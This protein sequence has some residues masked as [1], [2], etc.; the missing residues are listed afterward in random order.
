MTQ[1]VELQG[2]ARRRGFSLVELLVVIGI[3][4]MLI[5]LLL[6]AVQAAREAARRSECANNLRQLGLSVQLH[7]DAH[8]GR[9]PRGARE[10]NFLTWATFILPYIEQQNLYA[11]MSVGYCPAGSKTGPDGFVYDPNDEIEG[12]RYSR[13]QNRL[14]WQT[15][16]PTYNCPSDLENDFY[17]E[18]PNKT[19]PKV[20]YVACGGATAIGYKGDAQFGWSPDYWALQGQGGD[21]RDVVGKNSALFGMLMEIGSHE[22]RASIFQTNVGMVSLSSVK[23]GLSNTLAFSETIQTFNDLERSAEES[24][25]RGGVYR[26]DAAFFSCYYEPNSEY[27]DEVMSPAY[28]HSPDKLVTLGAPCTVETSSRGSWEVRMSARSRH[29]GGVNAALGDGSVKY[30][31]DTVDRKL[32]RAL[33][34]ASGGEAVSF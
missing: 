14:A 11:K 1:N 13:E 6:P 7:A 9:L 21:S 5:G 15:R 17:M 32:W 25:I 31:G 3:I 29:A 22:E 4:G 12:G 16:V 24:D 27:P 34:T 30:F 23:D 26:G 8:K 18:G 28:C 33:S 19:Y 20:S 10:W 2:V